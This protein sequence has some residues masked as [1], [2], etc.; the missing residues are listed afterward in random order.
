MKNSVLIHSNNPYLIHYLLK[1]HNSEAK[2]EYT[3]NFMGR[4]TTFITS[5]NLGF[6]NNPTTHSFNLSVK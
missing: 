5:V 1:L 4:P 6:V 3:W 2:K